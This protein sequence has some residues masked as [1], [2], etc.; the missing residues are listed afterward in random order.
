MSIVEHVC[1]MADHEI[2][3]AIRELYA[4]TDRT[5]L[6][7]AEAGANQVAT[8]PNSNY[9]IPESTAD[10]S[11]RGTGRVPDQTHI[12]QFGTGSTVRNDQADHADLAS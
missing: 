9:V 6:A 11:A 1:D 4:N 3:T 2:R 5:M 10:K 12:P 7:C 8:L